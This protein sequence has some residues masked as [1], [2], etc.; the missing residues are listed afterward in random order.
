LPAQNNLSSKSLSININNFPVTGNSVKT[1]SAS[2]NIIPHRKYFRT[3]VN[4]FEK[5]A[6]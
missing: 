4:L 1:A 6:E 5:E 3:D 2:V